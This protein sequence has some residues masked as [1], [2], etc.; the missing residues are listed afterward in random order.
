MRAAAE[1]VEIG[2]LQH[3]L[4][5]PDTAVN[6]QPRARPRVNR[7]PQ[8]VAD[9]GSIFDLAEEVDDEHV[10]AREGIDDPGVLAAAASLAC[11]DT[12]YDLLQIG[13]QRH[14]PRRYGP[15]H[16]HT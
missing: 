12:L 8:V 14:H 11:T 9:K 5:I 10:P 2:Q 16:K 1:D 15:A 7:R 3:P 13:S 6:D 4:Q